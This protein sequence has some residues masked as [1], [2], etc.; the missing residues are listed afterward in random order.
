MATFDPAERSKIGNPPV[1]L[2][3]RI[4]GFVL[5]HR[6]WVVVGWLVVLVAGGAA[7]GSLSKRLS[8]DFSLP[9][10][11]GYETAKKITDI[12]GPNSGFM[13]PTIAVVTTPKGETVTGDAAAIDAAMTTAAK[14]VEGSRIVDYGNTH[15]ADLVSKDGRTTIAL[16]FSPLPKTFGGDPVTENL[17]AGLKANLPAGY[18][19]GITA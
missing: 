8:V 5:H 17:R 16:V 6:K 10:Q 4:G 18:D 3:G 9:G 13:P 1:S 19:V 15:D 7:S 12:Y 14:N 2:L 11:P